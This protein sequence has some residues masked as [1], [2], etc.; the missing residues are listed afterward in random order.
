L[1]D[2][3]LE[4]KE[5]VENLFK[6]TP[7]QIAEENAL[8]A[9]VKRIEAYEKKARADREEL[10]NL[11]ESPRT[12]AAET[13]G[14]EG[15][16]GM[17]ILHAT[18][19]AADKSRVKQQQRKQSVSQVSVTPG[20]V[21]AQDTSASARDEVAKRIRRFSS[22]EGNIFSW[23]ESNEENMYTASRILTRRVKDL[24]YAPENSSSRNPPSHSKYP[25]SS[26]KWDFR[27]NWLCQRPWYAKRWKSYKVRF[28]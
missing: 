14:Y 22:K 21:T 25:M 1:I 8:M 5:Y 27:R 15:S 4:R 19:I 24:N 23:L 10:F 16:Q 3:E 12:N 11:L 26:G 9:E 2:K 20:Q 17:N 18:L 28:S 6:R 7:E 13:R